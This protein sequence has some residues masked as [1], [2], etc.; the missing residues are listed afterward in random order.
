MKTICRVDF[1]VRSLF[2]I[3]MC[4]QL[5]DWETPKA[6]RGTWFPGL[7]KGGGENRKGRGGREGRRVGERELRE[8][9]N[10]EQTVTMKALF[11]CCIHTALGLHLWPP[12]PGLS[13]FSFSPKAS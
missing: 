2:K 3:A 12:A 13:L 8:V 11:F 10:A 5:P 4:Q 1:A 6:K 7:F 9:E